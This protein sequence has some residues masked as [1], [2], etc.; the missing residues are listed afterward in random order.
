MLRFF[1]CIALTLICLSLPKDA[2][3]FVDEVE[4][5]PSTPIAGNSFDLSF[6][7]GI[8]HCFDCGTPNSPPLKI[9]VQGSEV[10]VIAHGSIASGTWCNFPIAT[11]TINMPP[12]NSGNYLLNIKIIHDDLITGKVETT[13][14]S[15]NFSV[16]SSGRYEAPSR[17]NTLDEKYLFVLSFIIVIL[18]V[19]YVKD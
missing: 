18:G 14:A 7:V 17:V 15:K 13:V 10:N 4:L 19:K 8:C 5:I 6:R 11:G 3:A 16:H 1:A 12:L 2:H 9:D